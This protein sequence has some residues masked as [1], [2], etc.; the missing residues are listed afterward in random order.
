MTL[1]T[2]NL[3]GSLVSGLRRVPDL[4][5]VS[6]QDSCGVANQACEQKLRKR[7]NQLIAEQMPFV[8]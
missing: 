2:R 8:S 5:P 7:T 3:S 4:L 6:L 1:K